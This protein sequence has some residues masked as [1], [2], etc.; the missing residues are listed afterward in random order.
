MPVLLN[1]A[2]LHQKSRV[3][4]EPLALLPKS[5]RLQGDTCCESGLLGNPE[6]LQSQGA[7]LDQLAVCPP[8]VCSDLDRAHVGLDYGEGRLGFRV[9]GGDT[10][11]PEVPCGNVILQS[12]TH[13]FHTTSSRLAKVMWNQMFSLWTALLVWWRPAEIWIIFCLI[14]TALTSSFSSPLFPKL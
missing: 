6:P 11:G 5:P 13:Y 3:C 9:S 12:A 4:S 14:I 7:H 2:A 10:G 8:L 1:R